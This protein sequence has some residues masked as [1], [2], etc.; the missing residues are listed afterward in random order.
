MVFGG[1]QHETLDLS[2]VLLGIRQHGVPLIL[3]KLILRDG[4]NLVSP[5]FTVRDVTTELFGSLLTSCRTEMY[6]QLTDHW[7]E[8]ILNQYSCTTQ[9]PAEEEVRKRHWKRIEHTLR[10]SNC[11]TKQEL[12]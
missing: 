11:I 1:S 2:F 3:R 12:I 4:F 5:S 8:V 9:L 10:K 6:L 7:V